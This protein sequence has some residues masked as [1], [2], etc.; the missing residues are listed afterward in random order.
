MLRAGGA[1]AVLLGLVVTGTAA[2]AQPFRY[3]EGKY[4]KGQLKYVNGLPVLVV[5]GTPEEMGEQIG[6]LTAKPL[7]RLLGFSR[8]F[9]KA[10]GWDSA[11]PVLVKMSKSMWPQFPARHRRELDALIKS[12]RLSHDLAVVGNTLPD[13]KKIGG[14]AALLVEAKRS[15]TKHL[16]FGRNLDYPTLGFLQEYSLVT[17]YRPKGKHAFASIGFP[18]LIGCITGMNDAGVVLA[19]LEIYSSRDGAPSLDP[20][21]VPYTLGYRRILEECTTIKQAV[22]LLRSIKRTTLNSLA[23]CDK[24]GAAVLEITPKSVV[25]RRSEQGVC[26]CTNHFCT[27]ALC[28]TERCWRLPILEKTR[29][30][31]KIDVA[32]V[33][34]KLDAVNQGRLTLQTMVF[35]PAALRLH[36]AIGKCPASKLPLKRLELGPYLKKKKVK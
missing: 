5:E 18:G 23:I 34:K 24:T 8:L 2:A 31:K 17:V 3:T 7:E 10:R 1:G 30:L 21:G 29:R 4:G 6:K 15:A 33:A 11:W 13:I 14:C 32:A 28:T 26:C 9:L 36:L 25:V 12:S 35:E 22:K 27:K 20:K 19:T 16:L